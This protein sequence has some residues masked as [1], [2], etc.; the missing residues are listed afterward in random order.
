[1]FIVDNSEE[2]KSKLTSLK[3]A[4]KSVKIGFVP[5]MGALHEGHVSLIQK[6]RQMS[7]IVVCSIFVNPTQFNDPSDLVKY[8]RTPEKDIALLE[9][10]ECDLVFLPTE[11]E[12]YPKG[13]KNY[14]I[15]FSGLDETME[16]KFR[17]GHFKG[18]AMVV[19][20]LFELV[21]PDLAFFGRKDF[22][23]VAIIRKMIALRGI[24]VEIV[25]CPTLRSA[26]G[27]ALSSRNMRLSDKEKE[28]ALIIYRT[29]NLGKGLTEKGNSTA[30]L[31]EKMMAYFNQGELKLE[32]LE[33]VRDSD[34]SVPEQ[35]EAGCT[36]CIAAWCGGV[37]LIDNMQIL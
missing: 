8:P 37:R 7:D 36:C 22:Q 18:V 19:E 5:T 28:D 6:A 4:Q 23:Q 2:L 15:N 24:T 16:G 1:M 10:N 33:I 34:L 12:V 21:Q 20:R 32:Y 31:K 13:T 27:L 17:P 25:D 11:K 3:S 35:I 29:L 30:A 9:K 26:S 14:Q